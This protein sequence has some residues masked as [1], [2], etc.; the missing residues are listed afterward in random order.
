M[1]CFLV[2]YKYLL[3]TLAYSGFSRGTQAHRGL[4]GK[5]Q[6]PTVRPQPLHCGTVGPGAEQ[7]LWRGGV[8]T[9]RTPRASVAK[10]RPTTEAQASQGTITKTDRPHPVPARWSPW[11]GPGTDSD[12]S[13]NST[14]CHPTIPKHPSQSQLK[15]TCFIFSLKKKRKRN[16]PN[17]NKAATWLPRALGMHLC[18]GLS[19]PAQLRFV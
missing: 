1:F 11:T 13:P 4:G 2:D 6:G 5:G 14:S 12:A 7:R 16:Q 10:G 17:K 9:G 3:H 8:T 15:S 18:A 19:I